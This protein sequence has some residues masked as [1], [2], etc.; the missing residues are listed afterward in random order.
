MT[1]APADPNPYAAPKADIAARAPGPRSSAGLRIT[2]GVALI[3]V[4]VL[5]G[6]AAITEVWTTVALSEA[7]MRGFVAEEARRQG[8][9]LTPAQ[10]DAAAAKA[11]PS[12]FGPVVFGAFLA[13]AAATSVTAAVFLFRARRGGFVLLSALLLGA[14][15]LAGAPFYVFGLLVATLAAVSAVSMLNRDALTRRAS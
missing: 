8:T 2:A 5:N 6:L 14:V 1:D 4:A 13:L 7:D 10:R 11:M 9:E 15:E 3:L 12:A